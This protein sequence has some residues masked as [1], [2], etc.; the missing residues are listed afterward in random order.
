M[1]IKAWPWAFCF[2]MIEFTLSAIVAIWA[3]IAAVESD[4]KTGNWLDTQR[5]RY[6]LVIVAWAMFVMDLLAELVRQLVC[7]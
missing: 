7:Y 2:W 3:T 4:S 6:A 1:G 5:G